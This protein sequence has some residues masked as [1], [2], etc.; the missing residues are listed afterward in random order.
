[1]SYIDGCSRERRWTCNN[2]YIYTVYLGTYYKQGTYVL[3]FNNIMYY[4]SHIKCSG[5]H[6]LVVQSMWGS[7]TVQCD[8]VEK[9]HRF[10][11]TVFGYHEN[12]IHTSLVCWSFKSTI[13][14]GKQYAHR[15]DARPPHPVPLPVMRRSRVNCHLLPSVSASFVVNSWVG[16]E[17][18]HHTHQDA[19]RH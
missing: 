1:M 4:R 5:R 12:R 10:Y 17:V 18:I 7:I 3:F 16:R 2:M 9:Q 8:G 19:S 11:L 14:Y 13:R 15:T 6:H